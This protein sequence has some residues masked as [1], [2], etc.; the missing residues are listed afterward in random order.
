MTDERLPKKGP[1]RADDGNFVLSE[2]KFQWADATNDKE[3][4]VAKWMFQ[5]TASEWNA[6][7]QVE[8]KPG[9]EYLTV[10]SK[11]NDAQLV[12]DVSAP[13]KRF[14]L[15]IDAKLQGNAESQLFW[16]TK[17]ENN[18]SEDRSVKL[19]LAGQNRWLPYRY[20]FEAGDELTGLRFDPT[21]AAG[22]TLMIRSI[23]LVRV[24]GPQF[25]D[26]KLV[27]AQADF[28]QQNYAVTDAIDGKNN[29]DQDGWAISPQG[30][31]PHKAIFRVEKPFQSEMRKQLKVT[32]M[33][34]YRGNKFSLG[35]FRVSVT[36]SPAPLDFGL[37]KAISAILAKN[38]DIRTEDE[39]NSLR[40]HFRKFDGKM[41]ELRD[42]LAKAKKP[43]PE[44]PDL[45]KLEMKVAE[46]KK[47]IKVDQALLRLR[48]YVE[49]SKNQVKNKRLTA[50][51]DVAW[52]LINNPA[53]LF[54]H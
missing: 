2:L 46:A 5:K 9:E 4:E 21:A 49:A 25:M 35:R 54:N 24:D 8:L 18:I 17:K 23:K 30:G 6:N 29:D 12:R 28:S 50:A 38:A 43:L 27:D 10:I 15:E 19:S 33:Q 26:L 51:Q 40:E 39:K 37:P 7:E 11:G 45:K 13:G 48:G 34:N 3:T 16:R 53:F 42:A 1:G 52:A 36:T 31:K 44:D 41:N 20:Y 22:T 14:M 47:P 32:M